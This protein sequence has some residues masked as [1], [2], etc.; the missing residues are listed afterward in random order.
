MVE[1]SEWLAVVDSDS[2]WRAGHDASS[3]AR[4]RTE[5]VPSRDREREQEAGFS[6]SQEN[7]EYTQAANTC[8]RRRRQATRPKQEDQATLAVRPRTEPKQASNRIIFPRPAHAVYYTVQVRKPEQTK[9]P[10]SEHL[11]ET[12]SHRRPHRGRQRS[13]IPSWG[14]ELHAKRKPNPTRPLQHRR[15]FSECL[16]WEPCHAINTQREG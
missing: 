7:L 4:V 6:A 15:I 10:T 14:R 13:F 3:T 12:K 8:Q 11:A 2:R 9:P 1:Q 5:Y 16:F